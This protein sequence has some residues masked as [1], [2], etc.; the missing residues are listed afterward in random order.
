M[1]VFPPRLVG[2]M[3]LLLS[4]IA[5]T[6]RAD[7]VVLAKDAWLMPT[8]PDADGNRR[9]LSVQGLDPQQPVWIGYRLTAAS[10]QSRPEGEIRLEGVIEGVPTPL[11]QMNVRFPAGDLHRAEF[12]QPGRISALLGQQVGERS[13]EEL[14]ESFGDTLYEV[15]EA[16]DAGRGSLL[17]GATLRR[18]AA[19]GESEAVVLVTLEEVT[20][21]QPLLIELQVGQGEVPAEFQSSG[22]KVSPLLRSLLSVGFLALVIGGWRRLRRGG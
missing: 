22:F 18:H 5:W 11:P 20:G 9:R 10:A 6:S 15:F 2:V 21:M 16:A 3:L 8:A 19:P 13:P 14:R 7:A 1:P 17:T 12:T 4:T